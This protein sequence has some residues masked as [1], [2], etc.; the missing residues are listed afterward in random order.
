MNTFK[1]L[2]I[3]CLLVFLLFTIIDSFLNFLEEHTYF[4]ETVGSEASFPSLTICRRQWKTDNFITFLDLMEEIRG[5]HRHAKT[6]LIYDE[7]PIKKM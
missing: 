5:F 4:E 2:Y 1:K 6:E 7:K 3:S